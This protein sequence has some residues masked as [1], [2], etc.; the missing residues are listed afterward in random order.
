V[1]FPVR[2][3]ATAHA[4]LAGS[5]DEAVAW[6]LADGR[7]HAELAAAALAWRTAPV[8]DPEAAVA[9]VAAHLPGLYAEV[10]QTYN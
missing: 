2:F 9:L 7:P 10:L 4:G 5:N 1:L 8:D 6:Y 3:L